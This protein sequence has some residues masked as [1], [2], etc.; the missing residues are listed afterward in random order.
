MTYVLVDFSLFNAFITLVTFPIFGKVLENM[1]GAWAFGRLLLVA[2]I[3]TGILLL[4]VGMFEPIFV[5]NLENWLVISRT[6]FFGFQPGLM[7]C[8]VALKQAMPETYLTIFFLFKLRLRQ[9]PL[10]A[11]CL[12]TLSGIIMPNRGILAMILSFPVVWIYLRF[13]STLYLKNGAGDMRESFS[14]AS[15]FPAQVAVY[16]QPVSKLID[17][18]RCWPS[19]GTAVLAA[20]P[21]GNDVDARVTPHVAISAASRGNIAKATELVNERLN[22]VAG[23]KEEPAVALDISFEEKS[24][25]D[26]K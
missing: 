3:G 5:R 24:P 20:D 2:V 17:S 23:G 13:F 8:F 7:A 22:S 25:D 10:F 21:L 1:Y 26:K 12:T 9:I 18:C 16:V 15:F 19:H 11:I 4:I 14:L 6:G